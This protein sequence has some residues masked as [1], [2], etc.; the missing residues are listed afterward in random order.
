M[1]K[2]EVDFWALRT[3]AHRMPR[4]TQKD[5]EGLRGEGWLESSSGRNHFLY[6]L[7]DRMDIK[8][9]AELTD[10]VTKSEAPIHS[11]RYS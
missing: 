5:H 6:W 9:F 1:L 7:G 11:Y 10:T 2:D 8:C 3:Q 4:T